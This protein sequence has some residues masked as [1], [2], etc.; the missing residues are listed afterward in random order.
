MLYL[1]FFWVF[2][3]PPLL[4]G[5]VLDRFVAVAARLF[6]D[7]ARVFESVGIY[8]FILSLSCCPTQTK[9]EPKSVPLVSLFETEPEFIIASLYQPGD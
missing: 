8:V 9:T 1:H 2:S 4:F 5:D 3:P 6:L 7:L